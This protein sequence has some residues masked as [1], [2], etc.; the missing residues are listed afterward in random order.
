MF[1]VFTEN[2]VDVQTEVLS[3]NECKYISVCSDQEGPLEMRVPVI[4]AFRGLW[5]AW[6]G[7]LGACKVDFL[8][9]IPNRVLSY[10]STFNVLQELKGVWFPGHTAAHP[11]L[12]PWN[13]DCTGA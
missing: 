12:N 3:P 4:P 8:W 1:Q 6:L 5:S 11:M 7:G 10:S 2:S 9:V 13:E